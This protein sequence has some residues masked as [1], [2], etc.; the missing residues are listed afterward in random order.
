MI[1]GY[2]LFFYSVFNPD[3]IFTKVL[4]YIPFWTPWVMMARIGRGTVAGW[5]IALTVALMLAAIYASAWFAARLYRFGVLMYG[6][7]PDLHTSPEPSPL[8]GR[9]GL[10][11]PRSV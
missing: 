2:L 9:E 3:A 4:S 5:E 11:G 10:A 6:Q 1:S 7:R 8:P